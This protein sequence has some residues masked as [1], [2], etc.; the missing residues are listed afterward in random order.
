MVTLP[1]CNLTY[2]VYLFFKSYLRPLLLDSWQSEFVTYRCKD[3]SKGTRNLTYI[4]LTTHEEK[5]KSAIGSSMKKSCHTSLLILERM[6]LPREGGGRGKRTFYINDNDDELNHLIPL[7]E[8]EE[9]E[10]EGK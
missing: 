2:C 9:E 1:T 6:S 7:R 5:N 8:E 10:K 3:Q 4:T